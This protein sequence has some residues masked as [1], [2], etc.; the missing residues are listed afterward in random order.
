MTT[1]I[2]KSLKA[3]PGDE[4]DMADYTPVGLDSEGMKVWN[5]FVA[6]TPF[7][8]SES[9]L[10]TVERYCH[11]VATE[12]AVRKVM[13]DSN[14]NNEWKRYEDAWKVM[15]PLAVELKAVEYSLGLSPQGRAA[16]KL[17]SNAGQ[18]KREDDN[19]DPEDEAMD[20][21]EL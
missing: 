14:T 20:P 16:L 7:W 15:K 8:W 4:P 3:Q 6:S 18:G 10:V 9:D 13:N 19:E 11:L 21:D 5:H 17:P 2:L 1:P 12:R